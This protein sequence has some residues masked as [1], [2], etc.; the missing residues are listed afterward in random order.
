MERFAAFQVYSYEG[1]T[2]MVTGEICF[3]VKLISLDLAILWMLSVTVIVFCNLLYFHMLQKFFTYM[4]MTVHKQDGWYIGN[5]NWEYQIEHMF[6]CLPN[7]WDSMPFRFRS[8]INAGVSYEPT[9]F[10]VVIFDILFFVTFSIILFFSLKVF[11][12]NGNSISEII[13]FVIHEIFKKLS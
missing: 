8:D 4:K 6:V 11:N 3:G 10:F 7:L 13:F 5:G 1:Y 2:V 12:E 9:N